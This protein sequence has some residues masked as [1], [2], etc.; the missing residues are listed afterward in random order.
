MRVAEN[1]LRDLPEVSGLLPNIADPEPETAEFAAAEVRAQATHDIGAMP[2]LPQL[3]DAWMSDVYGQIDAAERKYA[4]PNR[5]KDEY[6]PG[7]ASED[8]DVKEVIGNGDYLFSAVHATKSIRASDGKLGFAD[9]GTAGLTAVLAE[10]Y[11]RGFIMAGRQT[12]SAAI[13][14][15]HPL[16][17]RMQPYIAE[18]SGFLDV[19]GCASHLFVN[20]G[21][22]FNVHAHLGL[23]ENPSEELRDFASDI[24]RFGRNELGLYVVVG[25]NQSYYSQR[26]TGLRRNEDGVPYTGQLAGSKPNMMNNFVRREFETAGRAALSMQVELSGFNRLLAADVSRKDPRTD[27]ISVAL[28]YQ[29]LQHIVESSLEQ[30]RTTK[31]NMVE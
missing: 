24:V 28:G 8:D 26:G 19:H 17:T 23:G 31:S 1:P 25:N 9:V 21:D 12:G 20:P 10:K 29:L 30:P 18:A 15:A 2:W 5:L 4:A 7:V 27:V 13:D 22:K 16:K 3:P 14:E 11:G 6:G